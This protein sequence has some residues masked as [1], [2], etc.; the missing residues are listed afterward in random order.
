MEGESE[1]GPEVPLIEGKW[2]TGWNQCYP[3]AL[4]TQTHIYT[5]KHTQ[6]PDGWW[7]LDQ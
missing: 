4:L 6:T 5:H 1:I 3:S 7:L 2:E